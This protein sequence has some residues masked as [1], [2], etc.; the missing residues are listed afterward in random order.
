MSATGE[1]QGRDQP[2]SLG[3]TGID[4]RGGLVLIIGCG[5]MGRRVGVHY[6]GKG[7]RVVGAARGPANLEALPPLG[8]EP[9]A[10]DLDQPF[11]LPEL[12]SKGG[13]VFYFAPPPE[14]GVDDPR[15]RRVL[16]TFEHHGPPRRVV[17]ISTTGVYGDCGGAWV[18]ENRPP[19]PGTVRARRRLDAEEQLRTWCSSAGAELVIL[20]VAGIYGP[21]RLPLNRIRA[22]LPLVRAEEAPYTNRIHEDDLARVCVAAMRRPVA[23]EVF[24]VSDGRPGTMAEYFDTV[25]DR[26]GL[27]RPRK[28]PMAE[29]PQHLSP[30]MLS[31]M[32]ESRRLDNRKMLERLHIEFRYPDLEA[33]LSACLADV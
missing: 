1:I 29:A 30:G 9:L 5:D 15:V 24:N 6:V 18:D 11:P 2:G 26:A 10:L 17:Y 31:Y 13:R 8:I 19:N 3:S 32:R 20:R 25:A 21:D 23:G 33:G 14:R 12:P 7:L 27:P 22:G 16:E 28:I 4:D